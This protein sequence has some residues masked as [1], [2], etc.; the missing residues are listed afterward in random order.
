[1]MVHINFQ[2]SDIEICLPSELHFLPT[3]K[4]RKKSLKF[5][6]VTTEILFYFLY[7]INCNFAYSETSALS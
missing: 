7:F 5:G 3:F 6:K 4:R 2:I 1:M